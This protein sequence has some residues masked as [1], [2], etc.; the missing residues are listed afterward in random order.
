M[1]RKKQGKLEF[2][3][4]D[5]PQKEHVLALLGDRWVCSYGVG[6]KF[7][8]FHNLMEIGYCRGGYGILSLDESNLPYEPEMISIIPRNYPH[9]T[10][11]E[12]GGVSAWEYLFLDPEELLRGL[13]PDNEYYCKKLSTLINKEPIFIHTKDNPQLAR[14]INTVM[15]EMRTKD[16]Y[17]IEAVQSMLNAILFEIARMNHGDEPDENTGEVRRSG[18]NAISQALSHVSVH[19]AESIRIEHLA[20]LCHMS[21]THFRRLFTEYMK[22]TPVEYINMV[23]VQMACEL[24]KKSDASMGDIAVKSGFTTPSTFNRNFKQLLGVTPYQWKKNPQNY[25][26]RLLRFHISAAKGW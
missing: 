9:T 6:I 20:D 23:R 5:L 19:Y 13:Y 12:A 4:Y 17:Y 22:M 3:Y 25:E 21:E 2:R 15:D 26:S 18:L 16:D 24:M 10:N 7:Q 14:L 1:S 8:H 11:S